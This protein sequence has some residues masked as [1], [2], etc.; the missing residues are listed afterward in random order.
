MMNR[1]RDSALGEFQPIAPGAEGESVTLRGGVETL[2]QKDRGR[3]GLWRVS[4]SGH[5]G[6]WRNTNG[7]FVP[8]RASTAER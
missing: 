6:P 8:V 1:G 3:T 2:R 5:S 4:G 7:E